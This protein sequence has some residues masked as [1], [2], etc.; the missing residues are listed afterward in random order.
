[1]LL[2]THVVVG[3]TVIVVILFDERH[4]ESK[5]VTKEKKRKETLVRAP[6]NNRSDCS[7]AAISFVH[8]HLRFSLFSR[9]SLFLVR[10]SFDCVYNDRLITI[11]S[12]VIFDRHTSIRTDSDA[13]H[14]EYKSNIASSTKENVENSQ[15]HNELETSAIVVVV[16]IINNDNSLIVVVGL[17]PIFASCTSFAR[18]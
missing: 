7:I 15:S 5:Q 4:V 10:L 17:P 11:F 1:V 18:N 6:I 9:S 3:E 13:S 8:W 12:S 2:Y 14:Y 16:V